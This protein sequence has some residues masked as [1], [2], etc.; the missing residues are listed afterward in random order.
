MNVQSK[1]DNFLKTVEEKNLKEIELIEFLYSYVRDEI[2]FDFLPEVDDITAGEVFERGR[3]QCNNK[4]VLLYEMLKHFK[5]DAR[6]HFSSI[7]K[8]IHRGFFP[9]LMLMIAPMELGHSWIDVYIDGKK[10][11]LDGYINDKEL[12]KGAQIINQQKKWS[13]G[14]SVA[15]SSCGASLDFSIDN[16][17]FVQMDGVKTDFGTTLDPLT[18]LRSRQNPNKINI[19]KKMVYR[20]MLGV[21][22]SR[23]KRVRA[24]ASR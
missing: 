8:N 13:I 9:R 6:V 19:F 10:I 16:D 15:E 24:L 3:G 11:Q 17:N 4:T 12:F 23:V 14:H 18:Y 22:Q 2:K 7:D 5:F 20:L 1:Y 21:I